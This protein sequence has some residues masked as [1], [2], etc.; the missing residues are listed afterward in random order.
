MVMGGLAGW[1]LPRVAAALL[2]MAV[3]AVDPDGLT[4]DGALCDGDDVPML[5]VSTTASPEVGVPVE[6]FSMH[7]FPTGPHCYHPFA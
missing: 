1:S 4:P 2:A 7:E 3:G 6:G 5:L